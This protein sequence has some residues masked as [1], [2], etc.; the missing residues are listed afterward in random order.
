ML[1]SSSCDCGAD[2]IEALEQDVKPR[3]DADAGKGDSPAVTFVLKFVL[4][5][6]VTGTVLNYPRRALNTGPRPGQVFTRPA[7]SSISSAVVRLYSS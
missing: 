7:P 2:E 5:F 1:E 4:T 3:I 6:S